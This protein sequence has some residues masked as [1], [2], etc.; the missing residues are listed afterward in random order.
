MKNLFIIALALIAFSSC[1]K[2]STY[3]CDEKINSYV[4]E[5]EAS[6]QSMPTREFIS[7]PKNYQIAMFKISSP[8]K[9][10]Q[11]WN[12]KLE[13]VMNLDWN[14]QELAHLMK[15]KNSLTLDMFADPSKFDAFRPKMKDWTEEAK[16]KL[17]WSKQ[18]IMSIVSSMDIPTDKQGNFV[19]KD[20]KAFL[21]TISALDEVG[22]PS[23]DC[24]KTAD[25]CSGWTGG[26][27]FK[28][29]SNPCNASSSGCGTFWLDACNGYC[30]I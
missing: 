15:L 13:S 16:S 27:A 8:S 25:Y 21:R 9:K 19:K 7:A 5:N 2:D 30:A 10:L 29:S 14:E 12:D 4:I 26:G 20:S 6:I 18:T 22:T 1:K 17:G 23:C 28:C 24:N 3:S 11:L